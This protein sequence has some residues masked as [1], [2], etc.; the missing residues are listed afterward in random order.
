MPK[1]PNINTLTDRYN[2]H[3][4]ADHQGWIAEMKAGSDRVAAI[5][6]ATL[7]DEQ[8]RELLATFFVDERTLG[9]NEAQPWARLFGPDGALGPSASR[10]TL[11]LALGLIPKDLHDDLQ[12]VRRIRNVFA[13][14]L[15]GIDFGHP[16]IARACGEL[17]VVRDALPPEWHPDLTPRMTYILTVVIAAIE[18]DQRTSQ[19]PPRREVPNNTLFRMRWDIE[20]LPGRAPMAIPFRGLDPGAS[21]S[22]EKPPA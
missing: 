21:S 13:H 12:I 18:L 15:H 8:L 10:S 17:G 5:V 16:E 20:R 4:T 3:L 9:K 7:L 1:K 11:A 2:A 14:G 19:G 6:G 22:E